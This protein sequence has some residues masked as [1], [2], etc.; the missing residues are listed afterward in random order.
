VG[1][2]TFNTIYHAQVVPLLKTISLLRTQRR[3]VSAMLTDEKVQWFHLP[4]HT[5]HCTMFGVGISQ[6][7][8]PS[9]LV[10]AEAE[11][12]QYP[13]AARLLS[14][15]LEQMGLLLIHPLP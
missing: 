15:Q 12:I 4:F 2:A 10:C 5:F 8:E 14:L 13:Q 6:C 9:T 7:S 1:I 11:P 3:N